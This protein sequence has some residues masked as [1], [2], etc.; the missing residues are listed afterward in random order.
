MRPCQ[1]GEIHSEISGFALDQHAKRHNIEIND[2][3][4]SPT[5]NSSGADFRSREPSHEEESKGQLQ[6]CE[7]GFDCRLEVL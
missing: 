2:A 1:I 3:C 5:R 7:R 4:K 6:P